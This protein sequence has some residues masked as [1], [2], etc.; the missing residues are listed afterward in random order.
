MKLIAGILPNDQAMTSTLIVIMIALI[1]ATIILGGGA[2][3]LWLINLPFAIARAR[4]RKEFLR[5]SVVASATI[6]SL[7]YTYG[8]INRIPVNRMQLEV[9]PLDP[10]HHAFETQV[11]FLVP[12]LRVFRPGQTIAVRYDPAH[13]DTLEVEHARR[14]DSYWT[15]RAV[16][17]ALNANPSTTLAHVSTPADINAVARHQRLTAWVATSLTFAGLLILTVDFVVSNLV[18]GAPILSARLFLFKWA[19]VAAALCLVM[20]GTLAL[21]RVLSGWARALATAGYSLA[22]LA[23]LATI[24]VSTNVL[25]ISHDPTPSPGVNVLFLAALGVLLLSVPASVL[26]LA[27]SLRSRRPTGGPNHS[28]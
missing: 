5:T 14:A 25:P 24:L 4:H 11:D 8:S 17:Q 9:H 6:L 3:L 23:L 21:P 26:A 7:H 15:W 1:S 19:A 28:S 20:G 10:A 12:R 16:S 2:I 22:Y 13:P 27:R 18:F